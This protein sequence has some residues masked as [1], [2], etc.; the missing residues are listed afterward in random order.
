VS[1]PLG[2]VAPHLAEDAEAVV[3]EALSNTVRHAHAGTVTVTVSVDDDLAIDVTDNG[4]GLPAKIAR[5]GLANLAE[6]AT[7]AGG[8]FTVETPDGGGTHLVWAVPVA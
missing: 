7:S 5:S 6:R 2:V 1:G 3:R 8:T 4:V